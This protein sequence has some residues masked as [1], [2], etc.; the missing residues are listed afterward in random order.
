[1]IVPDLIDNEQ[2]K[3]IVMTSFQ[4][5]STGVD[6]YSKVKDQPA[7]I[8][9]TIAKMVKEAL[10][11]IPNNMHLAEDGAM[12]A[13][14]LTY[15]T[16]LNKDSPA[17]EQKALPFAVSAA[18]HVV[19]A[20]LEVSKN[21]A[22]NDDLNKE[23]P[24]FRSIYI[25]LVRLFDNIPDEYK[26]NIIKNTANNRVLCGIGKALV[27]HKN[28]NLHNEV[29]SNKILANIEKIRQYL[30]EFHEQILTNQERIYLRLYRNRIC[31]IASDCGMLTTGFL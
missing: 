13:T 16:N 23:E 21:F 4:L 28:N 2:D 15:F 27:F 11:L 22:E 1:V 5:L 19:R 6:E 9:N 31:A 30:T 3:A 7:A 26:E 20:L 25:T 17:D 14:Y 12:M 24:F 29:F 18:K 10:V 8:R